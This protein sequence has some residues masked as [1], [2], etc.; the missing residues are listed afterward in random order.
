M[1]RLAL[2]A[3][4]LWLAVGVPMAAP[5]SDCT[6]TSVGFTPLMDE[7][8]SPYIGVPLGLYPGGQNEMPQSHLDAGIAMAA[9]VKP[10]NTIGVPKNNGKMG[11]IS[12]GM[13]NTAQ[14]FGRFI[15][16]APSPN[17]KLVLV[18]G[19]AGGQV[20]EAW[21]DPACPCWAELDARIAAAGLTNMQVGAAWVKLTTRTPTGEW[22][23][24]MLILQQDIE[25]VLRALA[26][27]FPHLKL[28][29]LSSRIYA[30]YATNNLSPEPYAYQSG[31]AV[32][33]VIEKQL[34][35][36]LPFSGIGRVSPWIAWGPYMWADGIN[37]R[38]D[39][40][41]WACGEFTDDG[42]HP[43]TVGRLKV[44]EF[45]RDFFQTDPTTAPWFMGQ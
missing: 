34:N 37:P 23:D 21:A 3:L 16:L 22:P 30:G 31:F 44:A 4:A 35:G 43:N 2:I 20:A 11:L 15:G 17:P 28:A 24:S 33:G 45:L 25:T 9:L 27:R 42:T 39:G 18:N 8:A 13:S 10:R 40:L 7:G 32:R 12:I 41:T 6:V 26:V 14:E 5:A 1:R 36:L 19:A 38:S 29:Y